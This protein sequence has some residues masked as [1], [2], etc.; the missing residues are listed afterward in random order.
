MD[1]SITVERVRHALVVGRLDADGAAVLLAAN[2]PGKR[3]RTFVVVGESALGAMIRLDPWVLAD[4]ADK[5][6]GDL[7][8]VAPGFGAMG[9]DGTLPPARLLAD[10]LGV[11]VTAPEG[12]PVA[13][14]DGSVFVHGRSAGWVCYRP[15]GQRT[16]VGARMPAPWWQDGL[17][18]PSGDVTAVPVGLW[19]R[20]PGAEER[21][22]DPLTRRIPDPDRMYVV[23]GAPGEEPPEAS[24][25][26]AVL[27]S[28]PEENRDRAVLAWYGTGGT[29]HE[30]AEAL[31]A[32]VR[33]AHG[34]PGDGGLVRTDEHGTARWRPFAVESV[35]RP[36]RAPVLDRWIAPPGL[37]MAGPGSYRLTEGWRVDVVP[38]GLVVRP[39]SMNLDLSATFLEDAGPHVD[40]MFAAEGPVRAEVVSAFDR[41]SRALPAGTRKVLRILPVNARA[42]DALASIEESGRVIPVAEQ[43]QPLFAVASGAPAGPSG[44]LVVTADGRIVPAAP[45]LVPPSDGAVRAPGPPGAPMVGTD[46]ADSAVG[47]GGAVE[48]GVQAGHVSV[49]PAVAA[50]AVAPS[51]VPKP[52]LVPLPGPAAPSPAVLGLVSPRPAV[53]LAPPAPPVP[54]R[55]RFGQGAGPA[56]AARQGPPPVAAAAVASGVT[57]ALREPAAAR[58]APAVNVTVGASPAPAAAPRHTADPA[59]PVAVEATTDVEP[60]AEISTES[61]MDG[62]ADT[63]TATAAGKGSDG[64]VS[65]VSLSDSLAGLLPD[66]PAPKVAVAEP[67][68]VP[69]NARS[70]VEQRRAMRGR[71]GSRYDV[72]TRAV[73]QLLSERP[74]L[75]F[76][77]GDRSALLAELAVVRVFAAEPDGDY[78]ADFYTCLADGLRRLP[79]ARTVVV[80]GIPESTDVRPET[81]VR[82]PAPVVAAPLTA[83]GAGPAEALIWTTTARRLD[84][85]REEGGAEVVLSGHTRLR[86]LAVETKPVRRVLLAED[87]SASEAALTRL[88]AAAEQRGVPAEPVSGGRWFGPLP[89]A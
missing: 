6:G 39:E 68:E 41:L 37:A 73:A 8:V 12:T 38:R 26:V 77:S 59:E 61:D 18:V 25:V 82:L 70:T 30:V 7:C 47:V 71:L 67:I 72:A 57:T 10:R 53:P 2:L 78:D 9:P 1:E 88:R 34:V 58:T 46:S 64:T 89:A 49:I 84:G 63:D 86:V 14:A 48:R 17:P 33:V 81:V 51:V 15:G 27:R 40:V 5:A 76:G 3:D 79:T 55:A 87:G 66:R 11:E 56:L 62:L 42:E 45:I 19:V 80:R 74:G 65:A 44:A 83:G 75:R 23:L 24:A 35:Y 36:G 50:A 22:H 20:R 29:G 31:G 21:P 52:P 60:A 54:V 69:E 16:R 43:D 28:L 13:L 85:L 4:I 32:P